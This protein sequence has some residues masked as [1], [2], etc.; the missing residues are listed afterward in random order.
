MNNSNF[1]SKYSHVVNG[2]VRKATTEEVTTYTWARHGS[3]CTIKC[4]GCGVERS[5]A[6][7]DAWQTKQCDDC[8]RN[9]LNQ[10][11]RDKRTANRKAKESN[12]E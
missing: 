6:T 5:V 2:S 9:S 1:Y 7:Q 10:R 3:V 8:Q 4:V 11:R 12:N